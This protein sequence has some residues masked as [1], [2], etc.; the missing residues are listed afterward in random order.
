MYIIYLLIKFEN[1]VLYRFF[2]FRQAGGTTFGWDCLTFRAPI[3]RCF[4]L[5][6]KEFQYATSIS[7]ALLGTA[8]QISTGGDKKK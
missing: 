8:S 1:V 6:T 5:H 2:Y 3:D 4:L 7:L